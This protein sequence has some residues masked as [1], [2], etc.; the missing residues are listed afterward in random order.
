MD[1][2]A[3]LFVAGTD[4]GVGKS[5]V[6]L[7]LMQG[8]FACGYAPFYLKPFQTGCAGPCAEGSD[9]KFIYANTPALRDRDPA[10]SVIY[11]HPE[12]RAPY[13]AARKAGAAIDPEMV[14]KVVRARR[15]RYAP[16]V[17]EGAGG[18]LVPITGQVM[19]V[20]MIAELECRALLVARAGL[21]T[22]NHTLLCVEA[23]RRRRIEPLGVVFVDAG[24]QP[25]D[26]DLTAENIS[27]VEAF[28]GV[29]V[30]GLIGRLAGGGNPPAQVRGVVEKILGWII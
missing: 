9:A 1:P 8:L 14:R 16:V 27:A 17:V 30:A 5:M 21:G 29:R 6:C 28:G 23:M 13:F 20:D 24:P 19:M 7:L 25:A 3:D 12:A 2:V 15:A 18:L 22:I 4:T 10:R 26:P 11:C